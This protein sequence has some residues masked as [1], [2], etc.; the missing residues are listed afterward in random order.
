MRIIAITLILALAITVPASAQVPNLGVF[1]DTDYTVMAKDCPGAP[2]GTV[3]DSCFVVANNVNAWVSAIEFGVTYPAGMAWLGESAD[4]PLVLG[5]SPS[6][7]A[8]SYQ[9]PANCFAS[10]R[11]L[12]VN[13]VW[14]CS[15]CVG[16]REDI[17]IGPHPTTTHIRAVEWQTNNLIDLVGQTSLVCADVPVEETSWGKLKSLYKD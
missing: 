17:V 15:S 1:F 5:S 16:G 7:V 12:T 11:V 4:S 3:L 6:G 8:I 14:M 13:F 9:I 10:Y 2:A